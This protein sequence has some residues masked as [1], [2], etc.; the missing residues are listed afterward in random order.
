VTT[1]SPP[2]GQPAPRERCPSRAALVMRI[3]GKP[4]PTFVLDP[5]R[6]NVLGRSG[7]IDIALADRLASRRH[8]MVVLS[9]SGEGWVL[10]DLESRNGTWLDGQPVSRGPLRDGSVIRIGMT[11][12]A[13]QLLAE[14]PPPHADDSDDTCVIRS[15]PVGQ[16]QGDVLRRSQAVDTEDGRRG[17]M[18]YQ[19][20]LRL[21][22]SRSSQEVICAVLELVI[23]H[24]AAS[25]VGWFRMRGSTG[26]EPVCVVPPGG[27]LASTL[28]IPLVQG[29]IARRVVGEGH[30]VW[31]KPVEEAGL[32][33]EL[34]CIPI[35]D[36]PR[37]HAAVVAVAPHGR[38][39]E[40]DFDLLVGLASLAAAAWGGHTTAD[41][42]THA[43]VGLG[44]DHRGLRGKGS[45]VLRTDDMIPTDR[46]HDLASLTT[47]DLD[48]VVPR[49]A[50]GAAELLATDRNPFHEPHDDICTNGHG[51]RRRNLQMA[52]FV[53]G[54]DSLRL[55]DWQRLLVMEALRRAGG[56]LTDAAR[57]LG[58]SDETLSR[59]I[60]AFGLEG[61]R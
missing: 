29:T 25:G 31:L 1:V 59:Q 13:F 46:P 7:A 52:S 15:G 41:E 16:L 43:A 51:D 22:A 27:Q 26:L 57:H 44:D 48:A 24:T 55:D 4:G 20:S 42:P 32:S 45:D 40:S 58:I 61:W 8:A 53:A 2:I 6:E 54:A 38:L 19:A 23:E 12:L 30:A 3:A 28:N 11:E 47:V 14:Q 36:G 34:A 5:S 18:L 9:D 50:T 60:S 49:D 17:V 39:R 10:E 35:L 21:L 33:T 56:S 37:P